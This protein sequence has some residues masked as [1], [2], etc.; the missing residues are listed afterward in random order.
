MKAFWLEFKRLTVNPT[1]LIYALLVIAFIM[2]NVWP[3][4]TGSLTRVCLE[5]I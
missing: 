3:L 5:T 1:F 2:L 4:V